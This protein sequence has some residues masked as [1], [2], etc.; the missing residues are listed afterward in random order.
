MP[1]SV[2]HFTLLLLFALKSNAESYS[3]HY[4]TSWFPR[5]WALQY[6]SFYAKYNKSLTRIS[7]T[8]CNST[9]HDYRA[10][11]LAPPSSTIAKQ[12]LSICY[13]HEQCMLDALSSQEIANFNSASVVLG[14]IPT[15][16]SAIGPTI[17]EISL[18]SIH[19]P[20]LA[21][22]LSLGAP[23]VG[24]QRVFEY[25][26]PAHVLGGSSDGNTHPSTLFEISIA[27]RWEWAQLPL[28]VLQYA[29]A[30]GAAA[31]VFMTSL[32]V[33]KKSILSWG[34][35]VMF[36]PFIWSLLSCITHVVAA[37][38]FGLARRNAARQVADSEQGQQQR[39][40]K[41]DGGQS[42]QR[43]LDKLPRLLWKQV[44]G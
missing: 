26:G 15:L 17:A 10:S 24:P 5:P 37:I 7:T 40:G 32:E 6:A 12:L 38:G 14:L 9:L 8:T 19:R 20:F 35:T 22:L 11:Y 1:K 44:K 25:S 41:S 18:L 30:A 2:F 39:V 42:D 3:G 21:F 28:S 23:A 4:F 16:L 43:L 34:C 13:Q 36:C 29:L 27:K 31:N 33:G